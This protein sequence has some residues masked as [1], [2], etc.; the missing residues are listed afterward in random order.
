MHGVTVGDSTSGNAVYYSSA[1]LHCSGGGSFSTGTEFPAHTHSVPNHT[2]TITAQGNHTHSV[3]AQ[4][5]HTHSITITAQGDHTHSITITAQGDHSHTIGASGSH[6]HTITLTYGIY[7]DTV[8]PANVGIKI[9][10]TD[11]TAVLGGPWGTAGASVEVGP[12]EISD[13]LTPL[14]QSHTVELYCASSQGQVEF[15]AK[16]LVTVQAIILT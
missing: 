11:R 12:L 3:T 7:E 9:N 4:G 6:T 2:H 5:D 1:T 14:Q 10:G 16:E 15:E 13:Y 8:Y